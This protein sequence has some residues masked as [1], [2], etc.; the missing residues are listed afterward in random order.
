MSSSKK[1]YACYNRPDYKSMVP[2]QD[3]WYMDGV[4]RTPRMVPIPFKM[5]KECQY[6][7]TELGKQDPRCGACT[8]RSPAVELD[9][10]T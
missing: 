6:T 10:S 1:P 7:H 5:N 4:S 3:G 2:A 8:R 9:Q